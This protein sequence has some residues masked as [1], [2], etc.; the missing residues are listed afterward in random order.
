MTDDPT[1][2]PGCLHAPMELLAGRVLLRLWQDDDLDAAWAALQDAEIR[3]W[4]GTGSASREDAG[5]MLHERR[6]WS[7]GDHAS[8]V[9]AAPDTRA[10]LGSLSLHKIDLEQGTAEIGY[11]TAQAVRGRGVATYAVDAACRWA[12]DALQLERI[13][14]CHAAENASSARVAKKA[15]FILEGR[16]RRAYR[17][18]DGV[19]HDELLWSRLRSDPTPD[20]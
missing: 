2:D 1:L 4:N 17:Y 14:L 6:D 15:G 11:W 3:L 8:W 10:L 5:R 13:E 12:F 19:R 20:L 18:G 9:I 7:V 16:R